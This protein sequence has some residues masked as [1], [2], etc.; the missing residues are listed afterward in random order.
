M[1]PVAWLVAIRRLVQPT[2]GDQDRRFMA[3]LV[4]FVSALALLCMTIGGLGTLFAALVTPV[5]RSLNRFTVFVYG[6]AVLYMVAE[7]DVW[8]QQR[9]SIR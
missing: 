6:A 9:E 4:L 2:Q 1:I 5:L 3:V 8:M 7:F